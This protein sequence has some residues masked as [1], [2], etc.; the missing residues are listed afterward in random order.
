LKALRSI[1]HNNIPE[2]EELHQLNDCVILISEFIG[3]STLLKHIISKGS[4]PENETV[5]IMEILLNGLE[6]LHKKNIVHRNLK[7]ENITLAYTPNGTD[8]KFTEFGFSC[9]LDPNDKTNWY[10]T[11]NLC[12]KCGTPGYMAPE[13]Y[14][15]KLVTAAAD[16]FSMGAILYACLTG[17][18]LFKGK[19]ATDIISKNLNVKI[20]KNS[21]AWNLLSLSAKDLIQKMIS[22]NPAKRPTI[23]QILKHPFFVN[24]KY[25]N[26]VFDFQ[27]EEKEMPGSL[28][29]VSIEDSFSKREFTSKSFVTKGV[30]SLIVPSSFFDFTK[31]GFSIAPE[32]YLED[33]D[34]SKSKIYSSSSKCTTRSFKGQMITSPLFSFQEQQTPKFIY[35]DFTEIHTKPFEVSVD[36]DEKHPVCQEVEEDETNVHFNDAETNKP[37]ERMYEKLQCLSN[38]TSSPFTNQHFSSETDTS[39]KS[40]QLTPQFSFEGGAMTSRYEPKM[41][42]TTRNAIKSIDLLTCDSNRKD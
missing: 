40:R 20:D 10:V 30:Q 42:N 29:K 39:L 27:L 21:H 2:V 22:R 4:L 8:F 36:L 1:E 3:G 38:I 23:D 12:T 37:V 26:K 41:S 34:H 33:V 28:R 16:I 24:R 32:F 9:T 7:P 17:E 31:T 25:S 13:L 5:Y 35:R 11:E 14:E 6:A 18:A 15:N 19:N